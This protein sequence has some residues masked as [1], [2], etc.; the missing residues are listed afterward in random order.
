M[1]GANHIQELSQDTFV[2][3]FELSSYNPEA[4]SDTF[5]FCDHVGVQFNNKAYTPIPSQIDTIEFTSEGSQ[6][7]PTL[8]VGDPEGVITSLILLYN[9]MEGAKIKVTR[10]QARYLDDAA[11]ADPTAIIAQAN[12][13]IARREQHIP[14]ELIVFILSNPIDVD[15]AKLPGRICVRTCGW[16]YRDPDTCGYSGSTMY[17]ITNERTLD[18]SKDKCA[19]SLAACKAR[20]GENAV[21]PFGGFPG[22]QRRN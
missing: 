5:R 8:T 21:L 12:Y 9:N 1:P 6:P 20:F 17:T 22:L 16:E 19:F 2:D 11:D 18:S 3:L 13:V 15:G 4:P 7:E 14:R 10:T